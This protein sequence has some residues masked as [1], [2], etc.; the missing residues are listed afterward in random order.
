MLETIP[1][2]IQSSLLQDAERRDPVTARRANLIRVLLRER[3]LTRE[4]L[5]QRVEFLMGFASFGKKSWDDNF[6][7]D[8]R[9]VKVALKQAGYELK[10]SRR[11]D[12][13]GYYLVGESRLSIDVKKEIAGALG[14]IDEAQI[15]IYQRM[16]PA[17]KFYQ[18]ASIINFGVRVA[19]GRAR[20]DQKYLSF[21]EFLTM[22]LAVL[23]NVR[24]DYMIGGAIAV[25]PWGE[26]RSTQDVDLVIHL[27]AEQVTHLSRELEKVDILLPADIIMKN[28][29]DIR[30]DIPMDAIH[31]SSGY[32]AEIFLVREDDTFRKIAFERRIRVDFGPE[33][34]KVY[35]H[36]P[37][38]LIIDKLLYYSLSRQTKHIR[39]IGS[40]MKTMGD[41]L[42]Y[43][44]IQTWAV[45]KQI[46]AV[47]EEIRQGLGG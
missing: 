37:E 23:H 11:R 32:K 16:D 34:G 28:L 30:G 6:Y 8:M 22:I 39:D 1:V 5:I 31:G 27:K 40:M 3:Y 46:S 47:W 18:A 41:E 35:V 44:Y 33:V 42:D 19:R 2:K 12:N 17:Q 24:I 21:Q 43:D 14:E 4:A 25:W 7:R 9:V 13:S 38:D 26:P 15:Q 10:Y 20:M 36:S 29:Y 45:R